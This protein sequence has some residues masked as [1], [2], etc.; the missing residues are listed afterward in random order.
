MQDFFSTLFD[1]SFSEFVTTKIIKVI[2]G[3]GVLFAG[4][5]AIAFIV[6]GFDASAFLGI[7][8]LIVSPVV[9]II[10]IILI[11]V[12]VEVVIVLFKIS[13][14]VRNMAKSKSE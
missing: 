11:R 3:I 8:A 5:V 1:F 6:K 10:Y 12:W 9:F 4:I 7:L 14:D 13:E 2:Y